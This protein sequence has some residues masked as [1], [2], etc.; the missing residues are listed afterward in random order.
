MSA[1]VKPARDLEVRVFAPREAHDAILRDVGAPLAFD[2][3][4][5]RS[6]EALFFVRYRKPDRHMGLRITGEKGRPV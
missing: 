5:D 4:K 2:L 3:R 6:L 1:R